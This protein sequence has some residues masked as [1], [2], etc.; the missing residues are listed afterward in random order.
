MNRMIESFL[1]IIDERA[2]SRAQQRFFGIIRA[3]QLGKIKS[4]SENMTKLA[5]TMKPEVVKQ[6]AETKWEDLPEKVKN[7]VTEGG[8]FELQEKAKSKAQ[9]RLFGLVH[10]VQQGKMKAPSP[11]I[12]KMAKSIDSKE[13]KKYAETKTKKLPEKV[14]KESLDKVTSLISRWKETIK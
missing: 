8:L 10:S 2:A 3:V 13:V 12:A 11:T 4:P 14:K 9:Q 1:K 6:F 7:E 5:A